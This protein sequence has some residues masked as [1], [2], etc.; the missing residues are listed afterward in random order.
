M[1]KEGREREARKMKIKDGYMLRDVAG[2]HVVVPLGK[3]AADFNGM[4]S[5]NDTGA[6]LWKLLEEDCTRDQLVAA[7]LSEYDTTEEEAGRGVDRFIQKVMEN[8]FAKE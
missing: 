6:F 5:L 2:N 1:E 7:V 4:I 8:G 3:E